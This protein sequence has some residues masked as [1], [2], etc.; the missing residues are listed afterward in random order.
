MR[1]GQALILQFALF[2]LIGFSVY[3]SIAYFFRTHYDIFRSSVAD[4]GR[5]LTNSYFSAWILSLVGCKFCD[6]VSVTTRLARTTA[7]YFMIVS[8][9]GNLT[10]TTEPEGISY[11]TSAH[12]L[13]WTLSMHGSATSIHPLMLNY[14]RIKNEVVVGN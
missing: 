12:N 9:D 1:S 8:L 3:G 4:V 13:N 14:S 6:I 5:R 11:T 2:F 7:G 10:T